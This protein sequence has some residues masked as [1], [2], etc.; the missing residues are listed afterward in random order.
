MES[1]GHV[2]VKSKKPSSPD[3]LPF[4]VIFKTRKIKGDKVRAGG[5]PEDGCAWWLAI[6]F[7]PGQKQGKQHVLWQ[8]G[9][10]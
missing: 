7:H 1:C 2:I 5:H 9:R 3:S 6:D 4:H 8:G 10:Q